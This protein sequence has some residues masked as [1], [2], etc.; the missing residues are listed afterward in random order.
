MEL[1]V[2]GDIFSCEK[3][4]KG[5]DY[6]LLDGGKSGAFYG[7]RDFSGYKL[8]GGEWSAPEPTENE[9]MQAQIDALTIAI[10]EG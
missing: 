10:L 7:I 3:A 6:I 5:A 4:V 8:V 1:H 2:Y 9:H